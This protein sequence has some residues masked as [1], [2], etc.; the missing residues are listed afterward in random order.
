MNTDAVNY[1]VSFDNYTVGKL[2]GEFVKDKLD[3]DNAEGPFNIE[4]TAGAP[5]DNNAPYFF[6]G[7]YDVLKPYIESGKLVVPSGQTEFEQVA[8]NKWDTATAMSRF[9]NILGSNYSDGTQLDVA[10][11]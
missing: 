11:C 10:L 9:Q 2:Q 3:L 7:A 4:F 6:N 8:T 5:A 1:Y